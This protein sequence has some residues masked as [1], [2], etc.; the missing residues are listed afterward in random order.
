MQF[1]WWTILM[2]KEFGIEST[3]NPLIDIFLHSHHL[4]AW[5]CI[6]IWREIGPQNF[7][8]S[9]KLLSHQIKNLNNQNLMTGIFQYLILL[10]F[11]LSSPWLPVIFSFVLIGHYHNSNKTFEKK[12][13]INT[14]I[15][16]VP[17]SSCLLVVHSLTMS[18]GMTPSTPLNLLVNNLN[19]Q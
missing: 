1:L 17:I 15:V 19:H 6:D 2:I 10:Y 3:N 16:H 13:K 12:I 7:P 18:S 5:C 11:T 4:F 9:L 8:L 14:E